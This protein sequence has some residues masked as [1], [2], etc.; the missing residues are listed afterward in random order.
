MI[1]QIVHFIFLFFRDTLNIIAHILD[2]ESVIQNC[3]VHFQGPPIMLFSGLLSDKTLVYSPQNTRNRKHFHWSF[4]PIS[5]VV[6]QYFDYLLLLYHK[7]VIFIITDLY[8]PLLF[9]YVLSLFI[10]KFTNFFAY[11]FFL[12]F[13][14]FLLD[15]ILSFLRGSTL[16]VLALRICSFILSFWLP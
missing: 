8:C 13:Y 12:A 14:F 3:V 11:H 16:V 6:V 2:L 10:H 4:L 15:L 5:H 1:F 7:L 9:T